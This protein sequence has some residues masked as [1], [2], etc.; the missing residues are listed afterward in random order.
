MIPTGT[1]P[2]VALTA[3]FFET[4][5][6]QKPLP[7]KIAIIA[8]DAAFTKNPID[9]ARANSAKNGLNV[10]SE[11]K[12][13][14]A[15]TNFTAVLREAEQS[16]PDILF[17]ADS[18]IRLIGDA[19]ESEFDAGWL[20]G[21]KS[22]AAAAAVRPTGRSQVRDRDTR[23]WLPPGLNDAPVAMI[24]SAPAPGTTADALGYDVAP[25]AY[26]Q[27]QVVEQAILATGG[28][29]E[30]DLSEYTRSATFPTVVGD[31]TFGQLGEWAEPRGCSRSSSAT[32]RRRRSRSS[33][34]PKPGWSWRRR[35]TRAES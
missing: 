13:D 15:T 20:V 10:V 26:A 9:G 5:A 4:A 24:T 3:G 1:D 25:F 8:A 16:S 30:A 28:I 35:G 19:R 29:D 21:A 22:P 34:N 2:N 11:T 14:L 23:Y 32:S 18:T 17:L 12:Y 33:R 31:V 7:R 6:R 27:L